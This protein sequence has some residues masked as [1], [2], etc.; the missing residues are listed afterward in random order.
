MTALNNASRQRGITLVEAMVALAVMAFGL[1]GVIGVQATLRAT[2]DLS[3]QRAEAVRI[4]QASVEAAR[5]F[6]VIEPPAV[7]DGSRDYQSIATRPA[8][9]VAGLSTNTTF[10]LST[11]VTDLF[12]DP[13]AQR[14][15]AITTTVSWPD[16]T[17]V[18]QRVVLRTLVSAVPPGLAGSLAAPVRV[19]AS[20]GSRGRHPVIP[21]NAID[22]SGEGISLF[23][24]PDAGGMQWVFDNTTGFITAVC[25]SSD[26]SSCVPVT[27]R[28]LSG[29][30]RFAT[31]T[32]PPTPA[33][34]ELPPSAAKS[35]Q[36]GVDQILPGPAA[37]MGCYQAVSSAYVTYFCA[38]PVTDDSN[39]RWSGRSVV[40]GL[41]L[42]ASIADPSPDL[43]RVCR[44][45]PYRDQRAVGASPPMTNAEHPLDYVDVTGGLINQN[46][47]VIRAGDGTVAFDCPADDTSTEFINGNTWHHQ[48][49]T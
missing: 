43:Y 23:K 35:V 18:R 19:P 21:G 28:L 1:V 5:G 4:A 9:N 7:P 45:T 36:V 46:F 25:N 26:P 24:P 32:T 6:S 41:N 33:D 2:G 15:K 13:A 10:T 42:A 30:V 44:Y 37:T 29:F 11:T 39:P 48:P 8:I 49:A 38:I 27:A 12:N 17:G 34:S 14:G 20:N 31:G 3:K 47:L 40:G 16:R 22:Q